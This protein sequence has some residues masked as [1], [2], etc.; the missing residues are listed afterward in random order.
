MKLNL[1]LIIAI[2]L[3]SSSVYAGG[4]EGGSAGGNGTSPK[5]TRAIASVEDDELELNQSIDS[6]AKDCLHKLG[7]SFKIDTQDK[8]YRAKVDKEIK[9][10]LEDKRKSNP[11]EING[12]ELPECYAYAKDTKNETIKAI[13]SP[14]TNNTLE[15]ADKNDSHGSAR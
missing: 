15:N 6:Y 13:I 3:I 8:N 2:S 11:S 1:L 12:P 4:S 9:S 14:K 7:S 5:M 10:L